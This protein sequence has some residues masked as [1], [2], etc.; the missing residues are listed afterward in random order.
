MS[1]R[2]LPGKVLFK[3]EDGE[4][5]LWKVY[6]QM[7]KIKNIDNIIVLTSLEESDD[8]I[9]KFCIKNKINYIRGP[10]EDV[11]SRFCLALE[12]FPCDGFVR[13]CADS[14]FANECLINYAID[15]FNQND[16]IYVTNTIDRNFP[17][18]LSIQISNSN[19][20]LSQ[21]YV[22]SQKFSSEHICNGFE[23]EIYKSNRINIFSNQL[24]DKES[25]A[26]DD[27]DDLNLLHIKTSFNIDPK[28]F[29][30]KR[31]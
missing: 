9:E 17:K 30:Y 2:R 10:L 5:V 12:T 4:T 15:V 7:L 18:G 24:F 3:F 14:P 13:I 23:S 1:S 20:F 31:I 6:S 22:N 19:E 27:K 21:R 16:C 11:Y 28:S 25:Y 8:Q 26:I 29:Y